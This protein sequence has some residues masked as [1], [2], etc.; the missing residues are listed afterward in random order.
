V[1]YVLVEYKDANF[2]RLLR[3]E[4]GCLEVRPSFQNATGMVES[5]S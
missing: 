4:L 2:L 5:R 1:K 3:R